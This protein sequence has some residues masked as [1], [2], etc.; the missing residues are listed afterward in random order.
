MFDHTCVHHIIYCVSTLPKDWMVRKAIR[1]IPVGM[2]GLSMVGSGLAFRRWTWALRHSVLWG[3]NSL[4]YWDGSCAPTKS[5][6]NCDSASLASFTTLT[7]SDLEQKGVFQ[8]FANTKKYIHSGNWRE[9]TCILRG[10]P[11]IK[12]DAHP[13]TENSSFSLVPWVTTRLEWWCSIA[14]EPGMSWTLG[15]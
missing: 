2:W 9:K 7:C 12:K 10:F 11:N 15:S 14:L 6:R 1:I 5:Q 13:G 8:R 3:R 4:D